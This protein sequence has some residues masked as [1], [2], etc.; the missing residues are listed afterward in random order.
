MVVEGER[1]APARSQGLVVHLRCLGLHVQ[2]PLVH[3]EV[4]AETERGKVAS[5]VD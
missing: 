2:I 4:V 1:G 3:S 5:A